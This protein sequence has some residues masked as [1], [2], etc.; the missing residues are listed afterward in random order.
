MTRRP[1]L[2]TQ[3]GQG[4]ESKYQNLHQR[5]VLGL[6]AGNEGEGQ[7][8]GDPPGCTQYVSVHRWDPGF[9]AFKRVDDA[10]RDAVLRYFYSTVEPPC[11]GMA[12]LRP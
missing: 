5:Y 4:Q 1:N 9:G 8:D 7:V 6:F 2:Q 11:S 12:L 3:S 10:T